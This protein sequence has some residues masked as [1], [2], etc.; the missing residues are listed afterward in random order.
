M[1]YVR[2]SKK[3]EIELDFRNSSQWEIDHTENHLPC[4]EPLVEEKQPQHLVTGA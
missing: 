3:H 1:L 2:K 4:Q